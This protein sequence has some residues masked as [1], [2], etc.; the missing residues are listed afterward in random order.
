MNSIASSEYLGAARAG[1]AENP[2][3]PVAGRQRKPARNS[4]TDAPG[5]LERQRQRALSRHGEDGAFL[6]YPD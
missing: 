3:T 2:E 1:E 4:L 6:C 5:V